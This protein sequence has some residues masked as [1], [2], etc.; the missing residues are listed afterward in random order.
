MRTFVIT[1]IHGNQDLFRSSLKI[2]GLKKS[3]RLIILGDV[4]DRGVNSKGV[5]DTILLLL[6]AGFNV[7]CLMGN[8]EQMFLN[9]YDHPIEY[10]QWML[11]G[12]DK[13]LASF[14]TSSIEKIP[15]KYKELIKSFKYYIEYDKF[16][17]VHAALN[18]NI[19]DPYSDIDTILWER[20]PQDFMNVNW[21]K[22]RVII[23]GHTPQS[24]DEIISSINKKEKIICI[25]NGI[26]LKK[27]G[28]GELCILQLPEFKINFIK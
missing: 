21:L 7:D 18:M 11:N 19:D 13:T 26:Y 16:I 1:D 15:L 8:H 12:G 10:N 28:F 25:D 3:D 24:K 17:F 6:D 22:D 14:L 4:I 5:L 23:H 2:V 27:N 20:N 9:A